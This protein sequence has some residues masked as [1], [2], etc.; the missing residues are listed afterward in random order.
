MPV[1]VPSPAYVT[2]SHNVPAQ[3][4][5]ASSNLRV[6]KLLALERERIFQEQQAGPEA[7]A[8]ACQLQSLALPMLWITA[9]ASVQQQ[10]HQDAGRAVQATS[11]AALC[12]R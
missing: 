4:A 8:A 11:A 10:Q 2:L 12:S 9:P 7:A 5:S 1:T 6:Y 3:Q